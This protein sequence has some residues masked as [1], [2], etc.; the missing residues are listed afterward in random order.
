MQAK[1]KPMAFATAL[2]I[3]APS[4]VIAGAQSAASE[5]IKA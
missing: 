4:L 3:L 1:F 5:V 2:A